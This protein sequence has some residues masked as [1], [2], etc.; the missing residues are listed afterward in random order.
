M[1]PS[2]GRLVFINVSESNSAT[3]SLKLP[4][5]MR[6]TLSIPLAPEDIRNIRSFLASELAYQGKRVSPY[7]TDRIKAGEILIQDQTDAVNENV[8][9]VDTFIDLG[10]LEKWVSWS[11]F[12]PRIGLVILRLI[13]SIARVDLRSHITKQEH[14]LAYRYYKRNLPALARR[15]DGSLQ[16]PSLRSE[17]LN[18]SPFRHYLHVW[19]LDYLRFTH[20]F[21]VICQFYGGV[22]GAR[23]LEIGAAHGFLAH[24]MHFF[25]STKHVI[26]DLPHI[27]ILAYA[28]T[29]FLFPEIEVLLPHQVTRLNDKLSSCDY[30]FIFLTPQQASLLPGESFDV[31]INMCSFQEMDADIVKDYF[32]LVDTNL[33]RG[34][35]FYVMNRKEKHVDANYVARFDEYPWQENYPVLF[36]NTK[37]M[38]YQKEHCEIEC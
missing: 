22:K 16:Q 31:A 20:A 37:T 8:A 36:Q 1:S 38:P 23:V 19:P 9:D 11:P 27:V 5:I 6:S 29:K 15:I 30:Q 10:N 32:D 13:R 21:N 12:N 35:I 26:I 14:S 33:V 34:G 2:K 25:L 17:M 3:G 24:L 7:W 28:V 18:N 4:T